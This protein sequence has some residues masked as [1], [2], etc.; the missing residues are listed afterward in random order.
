MQ[1]M[2]DYH[3][4]ES[5][6]DVQILASV[7]LFV[8]IL[9]GCVW[10]P[11]SRHSMQDILKNNWKK[12]RSVKHSYLFSIAVSLAGL[13][14]FPLPRTVRC[15]L[16]F[17]SPELHIIIITFSV[18]RLRWFCLFCS[19][20]TSMHTL[21]A[22]VHAPKQAW[23][24]CMCPAH[25]FWTTTLSLPWL[26]F[27]CFFF[28][29][30]L[31]IFSIQLVAAEICFFSQIVHWCMLIPEQLSVFAW[32]WSQ[33]RDFCETWAQMSQYG[34]SATYLYQMLFSGSS[35]LLPLRRRDPLCPQKACRGRRDGPGPSSGHLKGH[36]YLFSGH[37][38]NGGIV[39]PSIHHL[40]SILAAKR[41]IFL[42]DG[43]KR[44][45]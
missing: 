21:H 30:S 13:N 16:F 4:T 44:C 18:L 29:S 26:S 34:I 7:L 28:F 2:T 5:L 35:P 23:S 42:C 45:E 43:M 25:I 22:L 10:A 14:F 17:V 38:M 15:R 39:I 9:E 19:S 37:I 27:P 8:S 3:P 1:H 36:I 12:S 20:A 24:T 41:F 31:G 32:I 6:D 11:V 40:I 33:K